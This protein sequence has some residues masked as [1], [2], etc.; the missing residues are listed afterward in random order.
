MNTEPEHSVVLLPG[1]RALAIRPYFRKSCHPTETRNTGQAVA[2][3]ASSPA[4]RAAD[5]RP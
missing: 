5:P 3:L 2:Y 4:A 1:P